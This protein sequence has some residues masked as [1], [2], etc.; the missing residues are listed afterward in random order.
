VR[1]QKE[2]EE[3]GDSKK[4]KVHTSEFK[5]KVGLE[6]VRV[7]LGSDALTRWAA[8]SVMPSR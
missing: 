2:L 5:A 8:L 1:C 3:M 7:Y 4:R 6:A